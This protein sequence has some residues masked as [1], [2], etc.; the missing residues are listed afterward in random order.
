[1]QKE[2]LDM[3]NVKEL[4]LAEIY[5]WG[6]AVFYCGI[7]LTAFVIGLFGLYNLLQIA[8]DAAS[9]NYYPAGLIH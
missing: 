1:M 9:Q 7:L 6:V 5:Q 8:T 3:E 2:R 4:S